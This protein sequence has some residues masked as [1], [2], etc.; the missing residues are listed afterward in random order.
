MSNVP[1]E[2][3]L[4]SKSSAVLLVWRARAELKGA[5]EE[6]LP[7]VLLDEPAEPDD[8]DEPVELPAPAEAAAVAELEGAEAGVGEN[9]LF[10]LPKPIADANVPPTVMLSLS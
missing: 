2:P 6:E 5:A 4:A 1:A 8:P 3:L 10:P 7:D 9:V